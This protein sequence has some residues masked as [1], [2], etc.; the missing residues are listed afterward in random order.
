MHWLFFD[1]CND[2]YIILNIYFPC[3]SDC[4]DELEIEVLKCLSFIEGLVSEVGND[5]GKNVSI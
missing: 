1:V 2:I 3:L 4:N 5:T